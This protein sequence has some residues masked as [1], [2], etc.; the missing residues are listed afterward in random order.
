MEGSTLAEGFLPRLLTV[1][2]PNAGSISTFPLPSTNQIATPKLDCV[3]FNSVKWPL[4]IKMTIIYL[5]HVRYLRL[6][7]AKF[8]L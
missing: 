5:W 8:S 1:K 3:V 7:S 6:R 2:P 4:S